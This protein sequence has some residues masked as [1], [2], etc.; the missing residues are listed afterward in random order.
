MKFVIRNC[1]D[2]AR[3][4]VYRNARP[5]DLARWHFHFERGGPKHLLNVL[6]A[7]Q[8]GDGGYAHALEMDS[9]NP[10]SAP[11]Q[12]WAATEVLREIGFARATHPSIR[13]ILRYLESGRDFSNGRWHNT[14]PGNRDHP[15]A[16]WWAP[17][18]D[19]EIRKTWNPSA[20]LAGFLLRFSSDGTRARELARQV[21]TSAC[22][23]LMQGEKAGEMH[24]LRCFLRLYE[25]AAEAGNPLGFDLEA[26]KGRLAAQMDACLTRET[27][28]WPTTYACLPSMFISGADSPFYPDFKALAQAECE[29]IINSQLDD[30]S[31]AVNWAWSDYPEQWAVS[32]NWWKGSMAVDKM[33]FL[34]RMGH[35][36]ISPRRKKGVYRR[37]LSEI[38]L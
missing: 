25:Y 21:G 24:T 13:G 14:V 30:G 5:L 6:G 22:E 28:L 36:T 10:A 7:Y 32:R 20:A 17:G 29:H 34:K 3:D 4:F 2:S 33:L 38:D 37:N 26:M 23:A 8:N 27:A 19:G 12:T 15:H 9:W 16:P 18:T 11:I 1:F 35:L 31:W